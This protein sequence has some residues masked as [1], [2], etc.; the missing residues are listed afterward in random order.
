MASRNGLSHISVPTDIDENEIFLGYRQRAI[1]EK[2][3][4]CYTDEV[5][6]EICKL[7]LQNCNGCRI[8]HPI[9]RQHDCLLMKAEEKMWVYF[10]CALRA[11]SEATIVEVFM[12]SLQDI[13]P[14]VNWRTLFCV[15][16]RELLKLQTRAIFVLTMKY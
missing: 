11:V 10:D 4:K 14:L 1:E 7:V 3:L 2:L 8:D 13:K 12:N 6:F 15:K 16:N 5:A 9:Q